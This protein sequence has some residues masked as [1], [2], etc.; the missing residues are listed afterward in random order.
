MTKSKV[1][2]RSVGQYSKFRRKEP[3][4]VVPWQQRTEILPEDRSAEFSTYGVTTADELRLKNRKPRR[5]KMLIR[6][7]IEG[8]T[9]FIRSVSII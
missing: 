9:P 8:C 1:T 7:F 2:S 3:T 6:D 4:E 5:V